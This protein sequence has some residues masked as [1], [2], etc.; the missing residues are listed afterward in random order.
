MTDDT[1]ELPEKHLRLYIHP[2]TR[3]VDVSRYDLSDFANMPEGILGW[4][5]SV[6]DLPEWVAKKLAVLSM[7]NPDE[8]PTPDIKGVG[9]RINRSVYWIYH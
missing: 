7:I 8:H 1:D 4:Y 2:V 9:R 3:T 5:R 6:D